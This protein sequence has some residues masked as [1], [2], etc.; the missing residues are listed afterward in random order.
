[1]QPAT[2]LL[3]QTAR[4]LWEQAEIGKP[5][6]AKLVARFVGQLWAASIVCFRAVALMAR[7]MIRTLATL[8]N[9]SEAMNESDPNRLLRIRTDKKISALHWYMKFYDGTTAMLLMCLLYRSA[10]M[11]RPLLGWKIFLSSWVRLQQ[12]KPVGTFIC[13]CA[14]V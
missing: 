5:I 8:I 10:K 1:M 13:M 2:T 9:T 14:V 3:E 6:S 7:G 11:Q 4:Q 12:W